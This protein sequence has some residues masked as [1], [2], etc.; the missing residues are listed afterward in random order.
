M[1]EEKEIPASCAAIIKKRIKYLE[2]NDPSNVILDLLKHQIP[3][4]FSEKSNT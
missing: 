4:H 1:T 3:E 2:A